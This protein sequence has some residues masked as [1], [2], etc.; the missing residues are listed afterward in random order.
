M[1]WCS[2][3]KT[4]HQ[5]RDF[6]SSALWRETLLLHKRKQTNKKS[7]GKSQINFTT[8]CFTRSIWFSLLL[9]MSWLLVPLCKSSNS[10]SPYNVCFWIQSQNDIR[11]TIKLVARKVKQNLQSTDFRQGLKNPSP[12]L[13]HT[14]THKLQPLHNRLPAQCNNPFPWPSKHNCSKDGC[15][16][17]FLC[18][19]PSNTLWTNTRVL[20]L[21]MIFVYYKD[22]IQ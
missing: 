19:S 22:H 8:C 21:S 18:L 4:I 20:A 7:L 9:W 12:M 1:Y 15:I 17:S 5:S 6:L 10:V 16:Q 13:T 11:W 2:T 3:V 14:H